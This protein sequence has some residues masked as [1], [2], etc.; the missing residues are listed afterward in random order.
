M[1]TAENL[2]GEYLE[3]VKDIPVSGLPLFS[4]NDCRILMQ[5]FANQDRWISVKERLPENNQL[6][7]CFQNIP[8]DDFKFI[9]LWFDAM[10]EKFRGWDNTFETRDAKDED[11]F[12]LNIT[13]WQPLPNEPKTK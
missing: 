11:G 12:F 2:I 4:A 6:C 5:R 10:S 9:V 8:E 7:F 3:E 13:H 1:K